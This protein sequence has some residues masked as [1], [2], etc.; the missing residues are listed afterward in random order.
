MS[1]LLQASRYENNSSVTTSLVTEK[2]NF[3][4]PSTPTECVLLID[5][6]LS[7]ATVYRPRIPLCNNVADAVSDSVNDTF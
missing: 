1:V 6:P 7:L 2:L 5:S 4:L 3:S